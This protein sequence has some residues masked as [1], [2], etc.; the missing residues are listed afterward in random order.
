MIFR[1]PPNLVYSPVLSL[2]PILR[3]QTRVLGKRR[4]LI[5]SRVKCP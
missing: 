3:G 5:S 1:S 4:D 2:T